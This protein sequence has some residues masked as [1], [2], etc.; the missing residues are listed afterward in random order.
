MDISA[1]TKDERLWAA[2]AHLSALLL[3]FS[4]ILH[5]VAPMVIWFW[6][7]DE[8]P[9]IDD[10]AKE[11]LNFQISITVYAIGSVLLCMT[12]IGMVIGIPVL[13]SLGIFQVIFIIIAAVKANEGVAYRYPLNLRLIK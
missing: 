9:F 7:K 3:Y 11:A 13:L 6:K 2:L 1:P 10:Q 5:I 8:S 4:G 12:I